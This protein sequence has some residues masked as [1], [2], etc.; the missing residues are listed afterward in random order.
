M[1]LVQR[2]LTHERE[3]RRVLQALRT[4]RLAQLGKEFNFLLDIPVFSAYWTPF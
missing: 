2:L 3:K 1:N 4:G